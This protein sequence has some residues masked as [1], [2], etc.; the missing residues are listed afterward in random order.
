L[1]FTM[2]IQSQFLKNKLPDLATLQEVGF[3]L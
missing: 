2:R 3:S 1:F